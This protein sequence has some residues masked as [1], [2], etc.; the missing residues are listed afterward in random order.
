MIVGANGAGKTNLL[1]GVHL[2][3][4]GFSPRTRREAHTVRAGTDEA[5]IR[6]QGERGGGVSF[7]TEVAL[8]RS[9]RK[10]I[11]LDGASLRS[12]EVLRRDFPVLAFTPDRLAVVKGGPVIRRAFL[13]RVTGRLYPARAGLS[14]AYSRTLAQRNAALRR[15][16]AGLSARATIGPWDESLARIG[17][18]LDEAR[19]LSVG[20][21]QGRF[22]ERSRDLGLAGAS[23]H[24]DA[25]GLS[26]DEL[27][28]RLERDLAR[29]ATSAGPHLRD[30][31]IAAGNLE[32][33]S[34]GSQG[35]Q[36]IAL[37]A[38]LLAEAETLAQTRY[39]PPLLLLDDVLSELD[40]GRRHALLSSLPTSCQTLVTATSTRSLPPGAGEP[41]LVIEVAP[42][43]A[44]AR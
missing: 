20:A 4:Q 37:L 6:A 17:T 34:F 16:H 27:A 2:G 9:G 14:S 30:L 24:Y 41:A 31:R 8:Q 18:S 39:D 35:E 32:L 7:E 40:D 1:E 11:H 29:G 21:L 33:R 19:A 26:T 28:G 43:R 13:D 23:L 15:I 3:T 38:L 22:A 5:R 12:A 25:P 42:G 36:R 44:V 10:E